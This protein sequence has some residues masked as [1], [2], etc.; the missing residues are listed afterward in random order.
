MDVKSAF[1]NRNLKEE[2]FIE[3]PSDY[4]IKG[5]KD[6]VLK[7]KKALYGLKQSPR[8]WYSRIDEYFRQRKFVKCPHEYG[9]Y[10]KKIENGDM[11]IVCLYVDDLIF[12]SNNS[13]MVDEF[14]RHMAAEFEMT[15]IGLMSYYLGIEVKQSDKG[16]FVSKMTYAAKVLKEIN[17][18]NC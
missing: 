7:L 3:Q 1:L 12:T 16:I 8:A 4:E 15:D 17:M 9:L 13:A 11:I 6:K 5:D 18:E 10:V 14:K 2:V